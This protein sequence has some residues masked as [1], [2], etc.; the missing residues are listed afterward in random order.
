MSARGD[1]NK[2]SERSSNKNKKTRGGSRSVSNSE[3]F[4]PAANRGRN[5][6]EEKP[7]GPGGMHRNFNLVVDNV[8]YVVAART[9]EFNGETRW[10]VSVNG[11]DAHVFTWDS[12]LKRL[13]AIDDQASTLPDNL[14]EAISAKLR[15]SS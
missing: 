6:I 12:D 5:E 9:Y 7:E 10:L 11:N 13:K 2:K 15:R 14:E 1:K 8:P 3:F 4:D